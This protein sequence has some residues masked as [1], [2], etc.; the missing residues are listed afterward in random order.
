MGVGSTGGRKVTAKTEESSVDV[1]LPTCSTDRLPVLV[2]VALVEVVQVADI[3][4]FDAHQAGQ[5]LHVFI[6]AESRQT[7]ATLHRYSEQ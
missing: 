6:A 5:T 2:F 3:C 1:R 4:G 7:F